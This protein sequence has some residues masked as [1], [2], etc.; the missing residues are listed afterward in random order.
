M[1]S[2]RYIICRIAQ[3]FG[4]SRK[5]IRMSDAAGETHLLKEAEAHLG[6]ATWQDVEGIEQLS[7]EYW[8]LRKLIKERDRVA[9][10]LD[11]CK[12]SLDQAHDERASLLGI[13]NE[14]FEDL[15]AERQEV[16]VELE[17]LARKRDRI[18]ASA[19]DIRR[20]HDGIKT[21]QEVL[22]KEGNHSADELAQIST[23]LADLKKDF[24]ALKS[25]RHLVAEK[26]ELGDARV[27][28]IETQIRDR[29]KERREKASE[30]FQ[31]IG[32]ANQ[33]MSVLRAELSVLDTQMR[34][35][36][37]EIGRHVS[38]NAAQNPECAKACKT[39]HGL[40]DV[41]RALRKSISYNHKLADLS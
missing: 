12:L 3:A 25:E 7:V 23:Q 8:N 1:T 30:A 6:Q 4:Y 39:Y 18:V 15:I 26:I 16:L 24:S 29:K 13:S 28:E 17:D 22:T 21:K 38:R 14:P 41:M 33:Q 20:I 36:Y 37:T 34:Q 32:D 40:V 2:T 11:I 19:R 9:R 35:L 5:N 10:D 27:D 31:H